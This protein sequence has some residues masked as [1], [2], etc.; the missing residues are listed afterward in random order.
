VW[1]KA[2]GAHDGIQHVV[3]ANETV[4]ADGKFVGANPMSHGHGHAHGAGDAH[5][6]SHA[7]H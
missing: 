4:G 2:T 1:D 5:G 3:A 6:H 7:G